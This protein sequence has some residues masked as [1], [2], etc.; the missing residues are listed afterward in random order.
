MV[1]PPLLPIALLL[2]SLG[3]IDPASAETNPEFRPALVGNGPKSLVNRIDTQKLIQAGQGDAVVMFDEMVFPF[4]VKGAYGTVYPGTPGS[5]FLQKAVLKALDGA[6]FI[7][8]IANHKVTAVDFHGTVIFF[9][10]KKPNLRVFANQDRVELARLA[11]FV[12]PQVIGGSTKF[13]PKDPALETARRMKKNGVVVLSLRVSEKGE[14]LG[15]KVVSEDPPN[16]GFGAAVLRS[17]RTARF[18][19]GFRNGTPVACTFETTFRPLAATGVRL[20]FADRRC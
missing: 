19:P 14:L 17:F 18:V 7:P 11:D 8:A 10:Q 6:E 5:Q 4:T 13:D 2:F 1:R 15:S 9:S 12:S 16:L 20:V 3:G